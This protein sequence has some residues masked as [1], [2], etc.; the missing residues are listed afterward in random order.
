MIERH[1]LF[2]VLPDKTKEFETF[3][4][5]Q[6]KPAMSS[7]P[8]FVKVELLRRQGTIDQYMMVIGFESAEAAADW[9][10]SDL[11]KALSPSLKALYS[12]SELD[13]FDVIV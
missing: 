8:G 5:S 10:N 3:F 1:V 7:M 12:E 11:H 9:R 6:Y 4:Q 13:V 2:H